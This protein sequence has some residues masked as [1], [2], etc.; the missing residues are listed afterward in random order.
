MSDIKLS[1]KQE[2]VILFLISIILIIGVISYINV[3]PYGFTFLTEDGKDVSNW[4]TLVVATGSGIAIAIAILIYSDYRQSELSK[5]I[6]NVESIVKNQEEIKVKKLKI[7]KDTLGFH[8]G[9]LERVLYDLD[10]MIESFTQSGTIKNIYSWEGNQEARERHVE[11]VRT[12]LFILSDVLDSNLLR[13]LSHICEEISYLP[14]NQSEIMN[15]WVPTLLSKIKACHT[16]L[17]K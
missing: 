2:I 14:K 12:D 5:I 9:L 15:N 8:L 4:A 10:N 1:A 16:N 7:A 17:T 13:E 11:N 3:G 6:S